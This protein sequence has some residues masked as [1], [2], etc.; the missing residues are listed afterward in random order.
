MRL[1]NIPP[2]SDGFRAHTIAAV[3]E[4]VLKSLRL[5]SP[6]DPERG[7]LLEAETLWMDNAQLIGY[8]D[9]MAL[10]TIHH[11]TAATLMQ[12]VPHQHIRE[13]VRQLGGEA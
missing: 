1:L 13:C 5:L 4:K 6:A 7:L 12:R 9:L 11:E 10:G 8:Y 3:R 2:P